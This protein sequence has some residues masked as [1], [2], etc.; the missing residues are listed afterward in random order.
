MKIWGIS[1]D[2][3][4]S[5][6]DFLSKCAEEFEV[7]TIFLP[8]VY[9]PT[10]NIVEDYTRLYVEKAGV[11]YII[12]ER[13]YWLS[14]EMFVKIYRDLDES[15]F[16][17]VP[18]FTVFS[19]RELAE[20]LSKN[21]LELEAVELDFSSTLRSNAGIEAYAVELA[22]EIKNFYDVNV[23]LK[24]S[25][26]AVG[27]KNLFNLFAEEK[28]FDVLILAPV[29]ALSNGGFI[30][31]AHSN[32]LN[33]IGTRLLNSYLRYV[34]KSR[35]AYV[36]DGVEENSDIGVKTLLGIVCIVKNIPPNIGKAEKSHKDLWIKR[37]PGLNLAI[38]GGEELCPFGVLH[39][40]GRYSY[41]DSR[42]DFCGLCLSLTQKYT[43]YKDISPEE[44]LDET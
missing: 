30:F 27:A 24:F 42:C 11:D 32:A 25:I 44:V 9:I 23:F 17:V 40:E 43:F 21:K 39:S 18:S 41:A 7:D 12:Y 14:P 16:R 37:R 5:D 22:R 34:S 2:A 20:F 8:T 1:S 3:S 31:R 33:R 29:I 35:V 38:E 10:N 19:F 6:V 13:P 26:F 15:G 4:I 28:A 36:D